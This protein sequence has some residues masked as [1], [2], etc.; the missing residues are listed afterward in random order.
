[1]AT[2]A[3]RPAGV[4]LRTLRV[5]TTQELEFVDLSDDVRELLQELA[6]RDGLVV[7]FSRHTTAAI[8]INERE[9][10]LLEDLARLLRAWAPPG[11]GY[12]HDDFSIRTVNMHPDER[13]NGHAHCQHLLLNSSE[14]IPV[15]NSE[16]L[17]GE[18]Q[19]IFLVELDGPR[20][21]D[22]LVQIWSA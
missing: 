17:L 7:V 18:W 5:A 14:L 2:P 12:A 9:P 22:V 21:R 13:P 8:K 3:I 15:A 20:V 19:S 4:F 11:K 1:M 16:L 10:L 6:V